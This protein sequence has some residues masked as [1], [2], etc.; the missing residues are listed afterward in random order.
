MKYF[1]TEKTEIGSVRH[2]PFT[3][4][5][6]LSF[7]ENIDLPESKHR[8]EDENGEKLDKID[9]RIRAEQAGS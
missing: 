3:A 4:G 6:A 1:V 7:V 2:G 9:L 5:V 8:I